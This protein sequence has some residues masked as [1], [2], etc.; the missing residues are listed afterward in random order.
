MIIVTSHI[1]ANVI[2]ARVALSHRT[3]F[4]L[5]AFNTHAMHIRH[6]EVENM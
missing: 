2:F 4:Y 6:T 1:K 3:F 5:T